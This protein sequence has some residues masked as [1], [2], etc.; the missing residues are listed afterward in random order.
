MLDATGA[1]YLNSDS[2]KISRL[3]TLFELWQ[4][5]FWDVFSD[6]R[7]IKGHLLDPDIGFLGPGAPG[8]TLT[9]LETARSSREIRDFFV[10]CQS[11][12]KVRLINSNIFVSHRVWGSYMVKSNQSGENTSNSIDK[13]HLWRLQSG[14]IHPWILVNFPVTRI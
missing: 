8:E 9:S 3:W 5:D 12:L 11:P 2:A 14:C 7:G 4:K 6:R 13:M 10:F 1:T